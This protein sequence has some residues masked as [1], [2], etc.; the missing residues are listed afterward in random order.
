MII[1][2]NVVKVVKAVYQIKEGWWLAGINQGSLSVFC[3]PFN[4]VA[5]ICESVFFTRKRRYE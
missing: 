5:S 4:F 2:L 1:F 3:C